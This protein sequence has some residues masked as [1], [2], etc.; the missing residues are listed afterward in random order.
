MANHRFSKISS[1]NYALRLKALLRYSSSSIL[2]FFLSPSAFSNSYNQ[3][4]L[5]LWIGYS[6]T[7]IGYNF[8]YSSNREHSLIKN[9][10]SFI[11]YQND[12]KIKKKTFLSA[13]NRRT[14]FWTTDGSDPTN[15]KRT[16]VL[17]YI[18]SCKRSRN[19]RSAMEGYL[20]FTSFSN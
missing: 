15:G 1:Q 11:L 18:R 10:R 19:D 20:I 14:F 7:W 17:I 3:H 13:G 12:Q 2:L 5:E 16:S 8:G 9:T 4:P 6:R